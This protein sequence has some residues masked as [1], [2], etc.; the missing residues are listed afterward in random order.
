MLTRTSFHMW[1][2]W[3]L[4]MFLF[5]DGLLTFS[6]TPDEA[7]SVGLAKACDLRENLFCWREN[8]SFHWDSLMFLAKLC[9]SFPNIWEFLWLVGWPVWLLWWWIGEEVF[10]CSLYISSK[11]MEVS[12]MYSSSQ[13][14]LPHWY[15]YMALFWFTIGSLSL[16]ET[17]RFL[18]VLP[19]WSGSVCH[20]CHMSFW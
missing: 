15:H 5:R 9:P 20:I 11:V 12:P 7:M 16:G 1:G 10:G 3:Y 18:M 19:L 2:R 4:P 6:H 14:R 17:R 8:Q 13:P